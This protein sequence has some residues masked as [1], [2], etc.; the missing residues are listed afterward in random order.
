MLNWKKKNITCTLVAILITNHY[1]NI[2]WGGDSFLLTVVVVLH[3]LPAPR[4]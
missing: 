1:H 4:P 2:I 3:H